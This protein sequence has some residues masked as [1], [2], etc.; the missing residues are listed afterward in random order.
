MKS[1]P[2]PYNASQKKRQSQ[3]FL[4]VRNRLYKIQKQ[5]DPILGHGYGRVKSIP[6]MDKVYRDLSGQAFWREITGDTDFYIKLIVL[7]KDAPVRHRKE[8]EPAWNATLNRFTAEFV[9]DFCF[10]NGS[11]DWEKIAQLVSAEKAE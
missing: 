7:M 1:G 3:E 10:P 4:A 11:I 6:N 5:F 2:F 9:R 8:Y